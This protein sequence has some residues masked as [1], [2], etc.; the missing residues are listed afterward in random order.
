MS[1]FY[2]IVVAIWF[3]C[4]VVIAYCLGYMRGVHTTRKRNVSV[5]DFTRLSRGE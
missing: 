2:M 5:A 3:A 1:E 4:F